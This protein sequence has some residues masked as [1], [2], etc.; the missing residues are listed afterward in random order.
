MPSVCSKEHI[1]KV[2]GLRALLA[3]YAASEDLVRVGAYQKGLDPL[4]DRAIATLPAIRNFLQ[5]KPD[6]KADLKSSIAS[7]FALPE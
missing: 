4:L 1:S 3:S 7:L 2:N 5:Q 6:E